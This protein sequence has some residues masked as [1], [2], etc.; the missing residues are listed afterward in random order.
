MIKNGTAWINVYKQ[1]TAAD[2][3]QNFYFGV[4]MDLIIFD[5]YQVLSL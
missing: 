5:K 2:I 4:C 3:S 1:S